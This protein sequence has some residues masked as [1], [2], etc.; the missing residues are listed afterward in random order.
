MKCGL[1]GIFTWVRREQ[2]AVATT[3]A[4]TKIAL[5]ALCRSLRM[6]AAESTAAANAAKESASK[7]H[8]T[9]SQSVNCWLRD[10]HVAAAAAAGAR[11]HV[12]SC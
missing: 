8:L 7:D 12:A 3:G 5:D 1:P 10:I 6:V 9:G 11:C 2:R 4:I